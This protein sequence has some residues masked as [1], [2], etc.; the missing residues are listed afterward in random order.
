MHDPPPPQWSR[1]CTLSCEWRGNGPKGSSEPTSKTG[2]VVTQKTALTILSRGLVSGPVSS[3]WREEGRGA[4]PKS[5][6]PEGVSCS[7]RG[8][9]KERLRD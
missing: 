6:D 1:G 3:R 4:K 5:S 8:A 7:L 2:K 9:F